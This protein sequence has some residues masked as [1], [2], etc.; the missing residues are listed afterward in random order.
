MD[1]KDSSIIRIQCH[2]SWC[3]GDARSQDITSYGFDPVHPEYSGPITRRVNV[4]CPLYMAIRS[5]N[6]IVLLSDIAHRKSSWKSKDLAPASWSPWRTPPGDPRAFVPLWMPA[7]PAGPRRGPSPNRITL[8]WLTNVAWGT[9]TR[10]HRLCE[11]RTLTTKARPTEVVGSSPMK[12]FTIE[13][14]VRVSLKWSPWA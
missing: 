8:P 7:R 14:W 10:R 9:S 6:F 3:P 13:R 2:G 11:S 5:N 1:D 4:T 12:Q